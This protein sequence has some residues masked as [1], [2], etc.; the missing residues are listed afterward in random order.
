MVES[1]K[2]KETT[3]DN[4]TKNDGDNKLNDQDDMLVL[5]NFSDSF[6]QSLKETKANAIKRYE[7]TLGNIEGRAE[8]LIEVKLFL[9][10]NGEL[11][12]IYANLRKKR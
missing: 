8:R 11:R 1:S 2:E 9:H 4:N 12:L 6:V 10:F 5:K 3:T 7:A